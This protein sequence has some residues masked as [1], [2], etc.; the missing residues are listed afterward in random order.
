MRHL[1][2]AVAAVGLLAAGCTDEGDAAENPEPEPVEEEPAEVEEPEPE[3]AEPEVEE[4]EPEPEPVP[5][6]PLTGLP[7]GD[8]DALDR[9]VAA[10]KIDNHPRSRPQ[11]G[12][13]DADVVMTAVIEGGETRFIALYHS[14]DPGRVGPIRSAREADAR[15]LPAFEP[16]VGISG[17]APETYAV[18][19][20]TDMPV[21][22]EAQSPGFERDPSRRA[23]HNLYLEP[24]GLW[25]VA[26]DLPAA[27][28]PWPVDVRDI[29]DA[30]PPEPPDGGEEVERLDLRFSPYSTASWSWDGEAWLREQ[31]DGP[32]LDIRDRQ[33][34]AA[35]VVVARVGLVPVGRTDAANQPVYDID[36]V[37]EGEALVLRDGRAY[38]A[39]WRK[40]AADAQFRWET[41][42]GEPLPLTAGR[43]WI[44]LVPHNGEV[45]L[46]GDEAES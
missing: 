7:V 44:E 45:T 23:P 4:P 16:V 19:R 30:D 15:L 5:T 12:L 6:A 26:D 46:P 1:L 31:Q 28:E 3:P 20:G 8:E 40:D 29:P 42:D 33:L 32:H 36:V 13:G 38:E 27:T 39:R 21:Y 34:G 18:L 11:S 2:A 24:A 9:P 25:S 41:P 17:A 10:I 43:T 37:G 35:N 14:T 22:E